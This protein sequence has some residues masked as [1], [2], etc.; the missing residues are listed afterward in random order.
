MCVCLEELD[1]FSSLDLN[2]N[3]ELDVDEF[4][5]GWQ[6]RDKLRFLATRQDATVGT[7]SNE[8]EAGQGSRT[9]EPSRRTVLES[10][11][12]VEDGVAAA[13]AARAS[14]TRTKEKRESGDKVVAIALKV[15][16]ASPNAE[17]AANNKIDPSTKNAV[18]MKAVKVQER[19]SKAMAIKDKGKA[20]LSS[21]P[22]L[23]VDV[24]DLSS[25]EEE[26]DEAKDE[27]VKDV[28]SRMAPSLR[29]AL[30]AVRSLTLTLDHTHTRANARTVR[31]HEVPNTP[32]TAAV[33]TVFSPRMF[34]LPGQPSSRSTASSGEGAIVTSTAA[35]GVGP[36]APAVLP[37]RCGHRHRDGLNDSASR[38][39]RNFS[40]RLHHAQREQIEL[41]QVSF[42]IEVLILSLFTLIEG[43]YFSIFIYLWRLALKCSAISPS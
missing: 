17:I 16:G 24:F 33:T 18:A 5:A 8:A 40:N 27:A 32:S 41:I 15:A 38:L 20:T 42:E 25:D 30:E 37:P 12:K 31:G 13:S 9:K 7:A 14:R 23:G 11:A 4:I 43:R 1:F 3:A 10:V 2:G 34:S 19:P 22:P 39:H 28:E 29:D 21:E 36:K 6:H 35:A 26:G